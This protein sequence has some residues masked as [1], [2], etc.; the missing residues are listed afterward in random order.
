[1]DRSRLLGYGKAAL[2]ESDKNHVC[3]SKLS[4]QKPDKPDNLSGLMFDTDN[5][6]YRVGLL[7]GRTLIVNGADHSLQ[8]PA[9]S[10]ART[11]Q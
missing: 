4:K 9:A 8:F 7:G 1:M 11:R 10:W 6:S 5:L 2:Q 3:I